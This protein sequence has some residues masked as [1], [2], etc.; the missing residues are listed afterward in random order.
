M[1]KYTIRYAVC[2]QTTMS[3]PTSYDEYHC[4][5]RFFDPNK[6]MFVSKT[7]N[8]TIKTLESKEEAIEFVNN[9]LGGNST[10]WSTYIIEERYVKLN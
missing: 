3:V 2:K 10:M 7:F 4:N 9:L 1:K 5:D 8:D 6:T